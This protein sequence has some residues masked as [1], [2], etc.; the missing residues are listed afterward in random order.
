MSNVQGT[1]CATGSVRMP[2]SDAAEAPS[3]SAAQPPSLTPAERR[4]KPRPALTTRRQVEAYL[5][6]KLTTGVI[7]RRTSYAERWMPV[8]FSDCCPE[9]PA[10]INRRHILKWLS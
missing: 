9:D 6:D 2:V 7:S 10:S 1:R 3:V 8:A 5:Q 4:H